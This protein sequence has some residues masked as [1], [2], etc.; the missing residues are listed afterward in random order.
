MS[1]TEGLDHEDID[2]NCVEVLVEQWINDANSADTW[3]PTDGT[4]RLGSKSNYGIMIKLSASYEPFLSGSEGTFSLLLFLP[5]NLFPLLI[6]A[7]EI[8]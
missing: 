7:I 1:V 5:I 4:G 2:I 3:A 6:I 8:Q